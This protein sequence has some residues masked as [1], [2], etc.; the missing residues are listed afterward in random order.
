MHST[1]QAHDYKDYIKIKPMQN[2]HNNSR[3]SESQKQAL[4]TKMTASKST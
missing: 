4:V 2:S 3:L 1:S